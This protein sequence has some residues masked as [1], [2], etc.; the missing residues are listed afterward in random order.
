MHTKSRN[1][2]KTAYI[3]NPKITHNLFVNYNATENKLLLL[4]E[5]NL[6]QFQSFFDSP[7]ASELRYM[8]STIRSLAI[9]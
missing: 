9:S 2:G 6:N 8:S 1:A 7:G 4:I 3:T 5:L